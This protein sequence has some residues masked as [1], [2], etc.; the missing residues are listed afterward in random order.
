M[1]KVLSG[2]SRV[3]RAA[4]LFLTAALLNLS[5]IAPRA[6]AAA[7]H[8]GEVTVANGLAVDGLTAVRGQTFFSGSRLAAAAKS[9]SLLSLGN[10]GRVELSEGAA[11][12]LDFDEASVSGALEAGRLRVYAPR[13]VTANFSTADARVH[14]DASETA[15]F[16]LRAVEGFT[17]VSVQSGALEVRSNNTARTLKAGESF[18]TRP[19]SQSQQNFSNRKRA[20]LIIAIASAVALVAIVLTARGDEKPGQICEGTIDILSGPSPPPICF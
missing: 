7:R 5:S 20:G 8:A 1:P 9:I 18:T 10:F 6:A 3:L 17:E 16:T 19:D 15:S 2:K 14:S 4:A 11:L 13:G 12:G